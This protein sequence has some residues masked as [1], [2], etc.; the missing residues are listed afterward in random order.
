MRLFPCVRVLV[1]ILV[2]TRARSGWSFTT[3]ISHQILFDEFWSKISKMLRQL[4]SLTK[5]LEP[6]IQNLSRNVINLFEFWLGRWMINSRQKTPQS[7]LAR[8]GLVHVEPSW[9]KPTYARGYSR[10]PYGVVVLLLGNQQLLTYPWACAS[11]SGLFSN[12]TQSVD[13]VLPRGTWEGGGVWFLW[14]IHK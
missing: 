2:F 12:Q 4:L 3:A 7:T 6:I 13:L 11:Y 14:S 10:E 8:A 9:A 5:L 1:E